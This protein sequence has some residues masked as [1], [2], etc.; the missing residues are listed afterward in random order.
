MQCIE[1]RQLSNLISYDVIGKVVPI[2]AIGKVSYYDRLSRPDMTFA[3]DWALTTNYLSIL[4]EFGILTS[5]AFSCGHVEQSSQNERL[6]CFSINCLRN[7]SQK[8]IAP[9]VQSM[10]WQGN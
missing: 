4:L 5:H 7:Y 9:R 2:I 3:V 10:L 6:W 8:E 1:T